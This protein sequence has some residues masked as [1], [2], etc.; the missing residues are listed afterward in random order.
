MPKFGTA[1]INAALATP[2]M[3]N[4]R[5]TVSE[6]GSFEAVQSG[7]SGFPCS[8][9][10][11]GGSEP[12]KLK[13]SANAF[14]VIFKRNNSDNMG[15]FDVYLNGAKLKTIYTNQSDGWGEAFSQ[16]VIKFQ[17]IKDMDIEIV[18]SEDNGDKTIEILG[19][20]STANE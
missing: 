9:K 14:F 12:L 4:E 8:W 7:T 17:S 11:K 18:P 16:Q 5:I 1:Y 15:S 2:E 6:T 3:E 13:T 10:Y 19:F 20:A